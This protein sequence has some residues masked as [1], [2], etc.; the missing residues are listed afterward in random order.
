[1]VNLLELCF[2]PWL[3]TV[4]V[5]TIVFQFYQVT[6]SNQLNG[7]VRLTK[8]NLNFSDFF[9]SPESLHYTVL[10]NSFVPR[11]QNFPLNF[12]PP[13]REPPDQRG[14]PAYKLKYG[15]TPGSHVGQ[16]K[17]AFT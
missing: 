6:N 11:R 16:P 14:C 15:H 9:K 1:M 17:M 5:S 8:L 10:E 12:P 13:S 2:V 3:K 4:E 7:K